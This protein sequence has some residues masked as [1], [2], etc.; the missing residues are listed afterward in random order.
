MLAANVYSAELLQLLAVKSVE[1]GSGKGLRGTLNR[2][3]AEQEASIKRDMFIDGMIKPFME[4]LAKT[5]VLSALVPLINAGTFISGGAIKGISGLSNIISNPIRSFRGAVSGTRNFFGDIRSRVI[6]GMRPD[7][8]KNEANLRE[9]LSA[10]AMSVQDRAYHYLA[11][12]LHNDLQKIQWLLGSTETARVQDRYTGDL[13]TTEE[14]KS[15]YRAKRARLREMTNEQEPDESYLDEAGTWLKKKI[16]RIKDKD[17]RRNA[18]DSYDHLGRL[19]DEFSIK[20]NAGRMDQDQNLRFRL[21]NPVN[22]NATTGPLAGDKGT[23]LYSMLNFMSKSVKNMSGSNDP[24]RDAYYDL[25]DQY[26]PLLQEIRDC[27]CKDC[28]CKDKPGK[29]QKLKE[30]QSKL[31]FLQ[32]NQ[33]KTP[34]HTIGDYANATIESDQKEKFYKVFYDNMP[35]LS[36]LFK[37]IK[38]QGLAFSGVNSGANQDGPKDDSD[39]SFFGGWF[40]GNKGKV[41]GPKPPPGK[42]GGWAAKLAKGGMSLATALAKPGP[43]M[44]GAGIAAVA[45]IG[46]DYFLNDGKYMKEMWN[47]LKES[48]FGQTLSGVWDAAAKFYTNFKDWLTSSISEAWTKLGDIGGQVIDGIKKGANYL[49][50]GTSH[51]T[52]E[53][54]YWSKETVDQKLNNAKT[55]IEKLN[56]LNSNKQF[57]DPN[58]RT[59]IIEGILNDDKN[60]AQKK[61]GFSLSPSDVSAHMDDINKFNNNQKIQFYQDFGK[62]RSNKMNAGY[63]TPEEDAAYAKISK[64]LTDIFMKA[65][66]DKRNAETKEKD[67]KLIQEYLKQANE[68]Q[69]QVSDQVSNLVTQNNKVQADLINGLGTQ[70]QTL[71]QQQSNITQVLN[72]TAKV[73][74]KPQVYELDKSVTSVIPGL[75]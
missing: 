39:S 7:A 9:S 47:S 61:Y 16:F 66:E 15:R 26:I 23:T 60:D 18:M 54:K 2:M 51:Q 63:N 33:N 59:T 67:G 62:Y 32:K 36:K 35:Y 42:A 12:D 19:Q 8:I 31:N 37:L 50:G 58:M 46:L 28:E 30:L 22:I 57:I 74:Q 71:A 25:M 3:K 5:P 56:I 14:L 55:N 41:Q 29:D 53:M 73:I 40:G 24:R 64:N 1:Q 75:K 34:D 43:M 45:S 70:I 11:N 27:V 72:V 68:V 21:S 44:I 13:V 6:D 10:N 49:T 48:S 65:N 52:Q 4:Q 17:F 38:K 69:L 20:G